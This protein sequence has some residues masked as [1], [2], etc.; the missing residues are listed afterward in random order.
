MRI[1]ETDVERLQDAAVVVASTLLDP[2]SVDIRIA[3]R[4][5]DDEYVLLAATLDY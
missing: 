2:D 4:R 5:G 3:M 1:G